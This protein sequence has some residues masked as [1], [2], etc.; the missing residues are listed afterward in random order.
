M[1][2]CL[3]SR[4]P[5][6][7]PEGME[8]LFYL[9]SIGRPI[10]RDSEVRLREKVLWDMIME[11]LDAKSGSRDSFLMWSTSDPT[12]TVISNQTIMHSKGTLMDANNLDTNWRSWN[13]HF[14]AKK[15]KKFVLF[16]WAINCCLV[17]GVSSI[18]ISGYVVA[19]K[20]WRKKFI[21]KKGIFSYMNAIWTFLTKRH[22]NGS[23]LITTAVTVRVITLGIKTLPR[24]S[25]FCRSD[26][27]YGFVA[28][29]RWNVDTFMIRNKAGS[30][31]ED[32]IKTPRSRLK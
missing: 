7:A 31:G 30:F 23:R 6:V 25:I 17:P 5:T 28:L 20:W 18:L 29:R 14:R 24:S 21:N 10:W 9:G 13:H 26:A 32:S 11:R 12:H 15:V 16:Y 27:V 1:H 3:R 2:L 4:I 8:N 19:K 22:L